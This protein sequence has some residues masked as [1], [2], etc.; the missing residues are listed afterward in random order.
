ML[1]KQIKQEM[2]TT[3]RYL[4]LAC[5]GALIFAAVQQGLLFTLSVFTVLILTVVQIVHRFYSNLFGAERYVPGTMS[6]RSIICGKLLIPAIFWALAG[7]LIVGLSA[8]I[9]EADRWMAEQFP[10]DLELL[11]TFFRHE[12]V[13]LLLSV[14]T[15]A[16]T[17]VMSILSIYSALTI[18]HLMKRSKM[19]WSL[20]VFMGMN[21]AL[22]SLFLQILTIVSQIGPVTRVLETGGT[23]AEIIAFVTVFI[24]TVLQGFAHYAMTCGILRHRMNPV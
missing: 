5:A 22:S 21:F 17:L 2:K 13:V 24:G 14:L 7:L 19:M 9:I 10:F 12:G 3:S 11:F 16:A 6:I 15:G 4:L 23:S 18:G 20:L 8:Q 1:V